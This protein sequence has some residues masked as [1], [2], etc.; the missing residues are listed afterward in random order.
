MARR[1]ELCYQTDRLLAAVQSRRA[2]EAPER[3]MSEPQVIISLRGSRRVQAGHPWI[4]R[5]DVLSAS[6]SA[7]DIV[8]VSTEKGRF[9]GRAFYSD[10]SQIT[11]RMIAREDVAID[12]AFLLERIRQAA[13]RRS[14]WVSDTDAYRLVYS[15]GDLLPSLI[16]DRYGEVLVLQTLSQAT[17]RLK[18]EIAGILSELFSPRGILERNDARTRL[19]EGLPQSVTVLYGEVPPALMAS[20]NGVRFEFDLFHGQKTGGFLDQ[21]ENYR[22]AAQYAHGEALDCFTYSGGFALTI[23]SR[24]TS[25]EALDLSAPA[26]ERAG[27][28]RELNSLSNVS[29]RVE[30]AFDALRQLESSGRRFDTVILDPPAFAKDRASVDAALRGYKEI[31][32]RSLKLLRAGGYLVTCSCSHHIS[33]AT[34]IQ[35]VAEAANDAKRDVCLVE[36]NTAAKDHPIIPSIPETYYLKCLIAR[37]L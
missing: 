17:D 27:R 7:G 29:F 23:A 22:A 28:N 21:R 32:L 24:C 26:I 18:P 37:V 10:R 25:V 6:A 35:T 15:E 9:V 20:I 34:F 33:E 12:R 1:T 8:R 5:S 2:L 3:I 16:V 14:E 36:R 19:R 4:Y 31:N 30:N 13:A 11:V